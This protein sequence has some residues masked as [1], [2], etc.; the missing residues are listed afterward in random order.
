MEEVEQRLGEAR[1]TL[2]TARAEAEQTE[3]DARRRADELVRVADER[4]T[5]IVGEAESTASRLRAESD[6]ELAAATQRR[7]AINAQLGNVRQML[8]SLSGSVTTSGAPPDR[9]ADVGAPEGEPASEAPA[10]EEQ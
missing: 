10:A 1:Q 3:A 7:E 2:E 8:A 4:A 5:A 9:P 6:R